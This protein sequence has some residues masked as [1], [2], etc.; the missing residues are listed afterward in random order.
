[1]FDALTSTRSYRNA[2]LPHEAIEVLFTQANTH[3]ESSIIQTFRQSVASYPKGVTVKLNTGETAVVAQY[4]FNSPRRPSVRVFKDPYGNE[5]G[6][7]YDLDLSKNLTV[8]I[9]ECDTI[10]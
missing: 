3:F 7:A 5:L 10:M 8:M 1:M 9:T 2:M 4:T 6:K